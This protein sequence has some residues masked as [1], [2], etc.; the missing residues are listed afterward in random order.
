MKNKRK[1]IMRKERGIS[2]LEDNLKELEEFVS[3]NKDT[4]YFGLSSEMI[5]LIGKLITRN[6]ELEKENKKIRKS[7]KILIELIQHS[8][9]QEIINKDYISKSKVR[10]KIDELKKECL[11]CK[12]KK[13]CNEHYDRYCFVKIIKYQLQELLEERN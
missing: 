5:Q 11:C 9:M 8:A 1:S 12:F 10:E 7:N 6:E 4:G 2:T 3:Q 13:L